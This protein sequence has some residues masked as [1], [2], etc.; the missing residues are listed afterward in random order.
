MAVASQ[1]NSAKPAMGNQVSADI[2]DI[3]ENFEEL[4]RI[5]EC[6]TNGT[7]G[8]TNTDEYQLKAFPATTVMLFGQS[9]APTAW[10]KKTDW[11]DLSMI[12]YTTGNIAQGGAV[13]AKAAHQHGAFTLAIAE[14][15]AHTHTQK[16]GS[17]GGAETHNS[18]AG[19]IGTPINCDTLT[20]SK[21]GGGSHQHPANSAPYYCSVI[22]AT[23]D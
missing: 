14:M 4:E 6:I 2:P 21:G 12:V 11:T 22:A 7:L 9:A 15:P 20:D 23:K 16:Y 17:G 19:N 10:T 5:I 1:W 13:D 3:E 8:T 18:A